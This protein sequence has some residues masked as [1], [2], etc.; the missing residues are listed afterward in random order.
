MRGGPTDRVAG[1]GAETDRAKI[2]RHRCRGAAAGA[3]RHP[4]QGIGVAGIARQ[5]GTDRLER[6]PGE[7]GHVRLSQHHRARVA[8][9]AHD[10][11]VGRSGR[12]LQRQGPGRGGH[13][14][15]VVI[16]L[17]DDRHAMQRPQALGALRFLIERV[18]GRERARVDRH[19]RVEG[20]PLPVIG[21]DAV[22]IRLHQLPAGELFSDQ[23]RAYV[24]DR[25]FLDRHHPKHFA[26]A[27]CRVSH[28]DQQDHYARDRTG[29]P[30]RHIAPLHRSEWSGSSQP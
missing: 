6:A 28:R 21:F 5:H 30:R 22:D 19:D 3:S 2:C 9:S 7:F 13:V 1:I 11:G 23:R 27:D 24:G 18:G 4:I 10:E 15:R 20:R 17:D 26:P 8:Q 16:V 25:R 14:G 29:Q 12:A